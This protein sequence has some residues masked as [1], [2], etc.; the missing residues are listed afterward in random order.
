MVTKLCLQFCWMIQT[1]ELI[2]HYNKMHSGFQCSFFFLVIDDS[3]GRKGRFAEVGFGYAAVVALEPF[4]VVV[5]SV[6]DFWLGMV[7]TIV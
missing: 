5:T 6:L 1:Y 3:S 7:A 2:L 4:S